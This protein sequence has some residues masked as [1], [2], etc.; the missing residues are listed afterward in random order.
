MT[1]YLAFLLHSDRR[2][3]SELRSLKWLNRK[4]SRMKHSDTDRQLNH[5]GFNVSQS[6]FIRVVCVKV[7]S[8]W[9]KV[10]KNR[11]ITHEEISNFSSNRLN[12]ETMKHSQFLVYNNYYFRIGRFCAF[13]FSSDTLILK[14]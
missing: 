11:L 9:K 2:P 4:K 1:F 5:Q 6:H 3:K 8:F 7:Q 13:C 14:R 10:A 12:F